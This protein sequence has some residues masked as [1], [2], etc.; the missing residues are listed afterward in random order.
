MI[1]GEVKSLVFCTG[2][3]IDR[4][5]ARASATD[6]SI[7]LSAIRQEVLLQ[8]HASGDGRASIGQHP[9]HPLRPSFHLMEKKKGSRVRPLAPSDAD[10]YRLLSRDHCLGGAVVGK[11][12][13]AV[14]PQAGQQVEVAARLAT[15][16]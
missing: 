14:G 1:P 12:V 6:R 11:E 5:G 10:G 3:P 16:L 13:V 9:R 2:A 7:L 4:T 15:M 8:N